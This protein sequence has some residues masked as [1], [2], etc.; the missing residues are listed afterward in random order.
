MSRGVALYEGK[1]I[2]PIIDSRLV[3]LDSA[4]GKPMWEARVEYSQNQYTLTLAPRIA[5]VVS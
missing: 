3:A 5:K 4:S 2:A 1:M